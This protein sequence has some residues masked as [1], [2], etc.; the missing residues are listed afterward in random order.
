MTQE[1]FAE[2]I[3][4]SRTAV[5]KWEQGKG[6]PNIESLK[7]IAKFF[8]VTIDELLSGDE[9]LLI[10]EED[11]KQKETRARDWVFGALDCSAVLCLFLPLFG[12]K[13]EGLIKSVSL[14]SFSGAAWLKIAYFI[15]VFGMIALGVAAFTLQNYAL[16]FWIKNKHIL[17]LSINAVG[18][19]LFI[20][21]TQPYAAIF[22]FFFLIIKT[23][24]LLRRIKN[25]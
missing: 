23:F 11:N 25:K 24:W 9:L 20:I 18:A 12:Q 17:S 2:K 5:S 21:S 8:S 4:V 3:Y 14:L 13:T 22:L 15:V 10:A 6:Y 1:E 7:M 16:G 19:I